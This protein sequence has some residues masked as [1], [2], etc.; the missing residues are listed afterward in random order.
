M[1]DRVR[2][3]LAAPLAWEATLPDLSGIPRVLVARKKL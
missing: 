3:L 1:E 2:N